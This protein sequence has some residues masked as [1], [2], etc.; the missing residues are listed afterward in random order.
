MVALSEGQEASGAT[1]AGQDYADLPRLEADPDA[2]KQVLRNLINNAIEATP[3]AASLPARVGT[4][5]R[6]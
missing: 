6:T 3:E 4:I 2:L 1:R 5:A